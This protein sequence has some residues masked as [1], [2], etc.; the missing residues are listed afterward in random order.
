MREL[1]VIWCEMPLVVGGSRRGPEEERG[2]GHPVPGCRKC[3]TRFGWETEISSSIAAGLFTPTARTYRLN[4][5][6]RPRILP[7]T[8]FAVALIQM[9]VPAVCLR[10]GRIA[11][12]GL[13]EEFEVVM[14]PMG[15]MRDWLIFQ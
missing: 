4:Q 15:Y 6:L 12:I 3:W 11:R 14:V 8:F 7:R 13:P 5:N 10:Q 1:Y 2:G 9:K